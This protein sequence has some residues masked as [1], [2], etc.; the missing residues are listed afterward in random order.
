MK[1]FA[2][3]VLALTI[4]VAP[5]C[6]KKEE[7]PAATPAPTEPAPTA[8]KEPAPAPTPAPAP[9]ASAD[10]ISVFATHAE[11]KPTDPVEVKFTAFSVTKA[12]FDPANLEGG[13]ATISIDLASLSTG[14]EKR[15]GHLKSESYID[16]SKFTT[17]TIDVGNVKK[18]DDKHY[19]ADAKVD[20]HG[21]QK[22]YPVEFEVVETGTDSV[23]IRGEQRFAR[24][25][26]NLGK[27]PG[28]EESVAKELQIKL[29]LT[30]KKT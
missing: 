26:F 3:L 22:T 16:L 11:P 27:E 14:S 12:S 19:T 28:K 2:A 7:A 8:V 5:A 1:V 25:D 21:A 17:A 13:T 4:A 18:K 29:Q 24:A 30:L 20:F 10:Y 9:A 15:D 23:K 6:K